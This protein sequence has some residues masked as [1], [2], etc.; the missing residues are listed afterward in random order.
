[1]SKTNNI[2]NSEIIKL[3]KKLSNEYKNIISKD[4]IKKNPII[5]WGNNGVGNRFARKLFNYTV[6]NK[7]KDFVINSLL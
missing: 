7:I 6:N 1:M 3:V 4:M 5:D 2:P